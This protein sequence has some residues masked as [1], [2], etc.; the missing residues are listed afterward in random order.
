M[1]KAFLGIDISKNTFDVAVLMEDKIKTQKF[2]NNE[3]GF[4]KLL[5][6]I[7]QKEIVLSQA[8]ME[9][10]SI[11]GQALAEF[12]YA[13]EIPIS[14]VNPARIKGFSQSELA[15]SKNDILDAKLI[16]RFCKLIGPELW[17]PT[18]EPIKILQQWVRR[19]DDLIAMHRQEAN[20]LEVSD[21]C[22]KEHIQE[23]ISHLENN[24][25]EVKNV[26]KN[27]INSDPDMKKKSKLLQ[28]IPGIGEATTAQILAFIGNVSKFNNAKELAAFVGLN[29]KQ[30]Q[31]GTSING[32]A[33][34][35][36][37]GDSALRKAFYM[38]AVVAM[39]HNPILRNFSMR[40]EKTG[41]HKMVIIGAVMR[42]LVHMIYGILKSETVFDQNI[43][44]LA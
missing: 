31:S 22:L 36:K 16:A 42:K 4:N 27:H 37:T 13:Q 44:K 38:P 35:S 32:R 40:L 41:K 2:N 5:V 1:K 17:Q 19:L 43:L 15:R 3:Q 26:I 39:R 6:W 33:R 20:R 18:P 23:N 7:N 8:C 10:T 25:K 29:P 30:R 11:Y 9:A 28:S 21:D 24:I 34:L 12:L 14:V